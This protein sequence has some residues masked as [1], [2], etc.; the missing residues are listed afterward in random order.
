MNFCV[1][2]NI[3]LKL[4]IIKGMILFISCLACFLCHCKVAPRLLYM[5]TR[6]FCAFMYKNYH[7][8]RRNNR[9]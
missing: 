8:V 3:P 6:R 7:V 1:T 4:G 5:Y 2:R 9:V